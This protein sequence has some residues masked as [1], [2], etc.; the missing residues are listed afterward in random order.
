M[1]KKKEK[2]FT[3]KEIWLDGPCLEEIFNL[4]SFS[5]L[6]LKLSNLTRQDVSFGIKLRI[7]N[8]RVK[9]PWE[10]KIQPQSKN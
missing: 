5:Y 10:L 8:H 7:V 6:K 9:Y 3:L 4:F 1:G 2:K